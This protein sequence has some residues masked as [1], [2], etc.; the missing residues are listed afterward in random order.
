M[1]EPVARISPEAALLFD[2]QALIG[3]LRQK[4][5]DT[6]RPTRIDSFG[7]VFYND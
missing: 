5:V 3:L 1:S 2:N 6:T 4:G 7:R